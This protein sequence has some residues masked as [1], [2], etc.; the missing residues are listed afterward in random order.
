MRRVR[1]QRRVLAS[2]L[3]RDTAILGGKQGG[4]REPRLIRTEH[5]K[6]G[7][8]SG[9][10]SLIS[11]AGTFRPFVRPTFVSASLAYASPALDRTRVTLMTEIPLHR[12]RVFLWLNKKVN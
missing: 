5:V 6:V 4:G 10:R 7:R 9:H 1:W 2:S 12:K 8:Q 3:C 11:V